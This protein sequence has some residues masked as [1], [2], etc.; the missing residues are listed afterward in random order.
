MKFHQ[1]GTGL[2]MCL[3]SSDRVMIS[4]HAMLSCEALGQLV[5]L[6]EPYPSLGEERWPHR[7]AKRVHSAGARGVLGTAAV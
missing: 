4:P 2:K 1:H 3:Q 7:A 6:S 5:N